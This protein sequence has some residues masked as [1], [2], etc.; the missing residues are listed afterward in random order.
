[1]KNDEELDQIEF[2]NWLKRN[3]YEI[4]LKTH[5]SPNGGH[6]HKAVAAKLK[7]MGTKRGFPDLVFYHP[8]GKWSGLVIEAKAR[9]GGRTSTEQKDWLEILSSCGFQTHVCPG[10][11]SIKQT[12]LDYLEG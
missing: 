4:W 5:H 8:V 3:H 7:L 10:I 2:M 12:F 1:M 6:R 11:D 9:K